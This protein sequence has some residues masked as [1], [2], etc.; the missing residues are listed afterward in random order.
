ML[1]NLAFEWIDKAIT[2]QITN[3]SIEL[4]VIILLAN[5]NNP[6][7]NLDIRNIH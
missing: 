2:Q 6:N 4:I 7:D 5:I 1:F 3:F